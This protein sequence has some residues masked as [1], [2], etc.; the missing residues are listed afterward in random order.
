MAGPIAIDNKNGYEVYAYPEQKNTLNN[1][2]N[3]IKKLSGE[4]YVKSI[5]DLNQEY[6]TGGKKDWL[7]MDLSSKYHRDSRLKQFHL[8]TF[9]FRGLEETSKDKKILTMSMPQKFRYSFGGKWDNNFEWLNG[10]GLI[11]EVAALVSNDQTNLGF[12]MGS[13]STFTAPEPMEL[14]LRF[15]IFDDVGSNSGVNYQEA[16]EL[17]AEAS[18]PRLTANGAYTAIPG[19]G[20]F[21]AMTK[22]TVGKTAN[23]I[24]SIVGGLRKKV[25]DKMHDM[26]SNVVQNRWRRITLQ[27][28]GLLLLDWCIIKNVSVEFPNTKHQVLHSWPAVA[29]SERRMHLQPLLAEVEIKIASTQGMTYDRLKAALQLT[30]KVV[31]S[32]KSSEVM[33]MANAAKNA[34]PTGTPV[35]PKNMSATEFVRAGPNQSPVP[36]SYYANSSPVP[37]DFYKK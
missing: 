21:I 15:P 10:G 16:L 32:E 5:S 11:G 22:D 20:A 14:V 3:D 19:P 36:D 35:K 18:L 31:N 4:N 7:S 25:G 12:D 2:V 6:N 27:L 29:G 8:A 9:V 1:T 30:T 28:G 23:G 37:D 26:F 24:E 17:L 13:I 34:C 33:D